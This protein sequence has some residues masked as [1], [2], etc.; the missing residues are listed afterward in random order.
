MG[1]ME[2]ASADMAMVAGVTVGGTYDCTVLW[3]QAYFKRGLKNILL[4]RTGVPEE[5]PTKVGTLPAAGAERSR[6]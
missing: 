3:V 6:E 5:A 2:E 4:G 1:K